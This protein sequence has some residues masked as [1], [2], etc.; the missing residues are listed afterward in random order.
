M[1]RFLP[2][3]RG[4]AWGAIGVGGGLSAVGLIAGASVL[5]LFAPAFGVV[6]GAFYL[7]SPTW[8]LAI[9]TDDTGLTVRAGDNERFRVAWTD[10]VKVVAAP[11]SSTAFID[12]GTPER[13]V[14]I[15]G[16]GAPAPYALENSKALYDTVMA[17]VPA[18]RV[19]QVESIDKAQSEK[20]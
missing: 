17:H 14:L 6:L 1:H 16:D 15:P 11:T 12:G 10:I 3:Y 20:S 4:L 8:R 19:Q 13:S 7:R 2:R 18:D 9:V 5:G